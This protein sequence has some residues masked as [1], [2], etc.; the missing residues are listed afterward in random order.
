MRCVARQFY[1]A[2]YIMAYNR[3]LHG[4]LWLCKY[5]KEQ[6]IETDYKIQNRPQLDRAVII[7]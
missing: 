5:A 3:V 6:I 2:T 4:N 1:S 7:N